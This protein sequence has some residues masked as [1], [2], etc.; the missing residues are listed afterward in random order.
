MLVY[1]RVPA[2]RSEGT[3]T[4]GEDAD[5]VSD[6]EI[7]A[8]LREEI[9]ADNARHRVAKAEWEVRK[10]VIGCHR[11]SAWPRPSG[12]SARGSLARSLDG[13]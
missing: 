5:R 10:G 12:R 1:R 11:V 6:D 3:G 13:V 2:R 4:T 8:E 9:A 7:P